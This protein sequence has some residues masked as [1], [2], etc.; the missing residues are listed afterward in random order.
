[1]AW[2]AASEIS[3]IRIIPAWVSELV[4][5][6][7]RETENRDIH[8]VMERTVQ[9]SDH[10]RHKSRFI[11]PA[12]FKSNAVRLLSPAER[13]KFFKKRAKKRLWMKGTEKK[14]KYAKVKVKVFVRSGWMLQMDL[15]RNCHDDT[16]MIKGPEWKYVL[17][18][19]DFRENDAV[20]MWA[21]RCRLPPPPPPL[22]AAGAS[23]SDSS[24]DPPPPPPESLCFILGKKENSN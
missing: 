3:P 24:S 5:R 21:F 4:R 18:C 20:E 10:N 23:S 16:V 19:C 22:A 12:D 6:Q 15:A 13:V 7:V 11:L 9:H 2:K 17:A 14:P 1:M 8:F